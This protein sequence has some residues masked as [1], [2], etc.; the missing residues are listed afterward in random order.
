MFAESCKT[1]ADHTPVIFEIHI[2]PKFA[3]H[4]LA[5][6]EDISTFSEE[7][8]VLLSMQAVCRVVGIDPITNGI[9]YIRLSLTDDDNE[10]LRKLTEY[11]TQE[12]S[13]PTLMH[14][15]GP[16]FIMLEQWSEAEDVYE[17]LLEEA[18][19]DDETELANLHY[20]LGYISDR[21][22]S[23][24]EA[25]GHYK[26]VLSLKSQLPEDER[27][28]LAPT[29]AG[30]ARLFYQKKN[31]DGALRYYKKAITLASTASP[32][33]KIKI[34]CYYNEMAL[35]FR[36]K[37]LYDEALNILD[38]ALD[39]VRTGGLP[40]THPDLAKIYLNIASVYSMGKRYDKSLECHEKCLDIQL[41][42]LPP[43]H[44]ALVRSHMAM[45]GVLEECN[46]IKEAIKHLE[47]AYKITKDPEEKSFCQDRIGKFQSKLQS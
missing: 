45:S 44:P 8:E 41:H 17:T 27:H 34:G 43:N 14:R 18:D 3:I 9:K 28:Q 15:L 19:E 22:N 13:G 10:K 21:L 11:M 26:E 24:K 37:H 32:I 31:F 39:D 23:S 16:L 30:I 1:I 35:I 20:Q 2:D 12:V 38:K 5:S 47:Q 40:L 46:S 42:S 25:L 4:R 6:I 7:K 29:Y 33:D 36:D